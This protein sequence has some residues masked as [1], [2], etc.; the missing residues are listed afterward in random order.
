MRPPSWISVHGRG[1]GFALACVWTLAA[2]AAVDLG[3]RVHSHRPVLVLDDWRM[4]RIA[5]LT[6]GDRGGF[7]PVLG[8]VPREDIES[9]GY[10]S[11]DFGI[12]RNFQEKAVRSGGILAVGD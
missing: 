12:R 10:N 9:D 7:D 1:A 5:F 3:Y 8:W 11:L 6:F 2:V 4:A